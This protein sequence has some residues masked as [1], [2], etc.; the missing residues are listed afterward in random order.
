M[1]KHVPHAIEG[2][3]KVLPDRELRYRLVRRTAGLGSL[4]EVRVVAIAKWNGST[5]AREAKAITPSAW[6]WADGENTAELL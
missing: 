1:R 3:E 5:I 2:I 4:G 6:Y